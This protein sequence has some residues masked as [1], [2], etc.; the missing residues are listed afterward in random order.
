MKIARSAAFLPIAV[1]AATVTAG[2]QGAPPVEIKKCS[3]LRY[4]PATPAYRRSYWYDYGFAGPIVPR[5]SP[6][7]DGIAISFVNRSPK[8]ADRVVFGVDYRGDFQHV[9]DAGSFTTGAGIDHTFADVFSG[10]AFLGDRPNSCV[11]RVVRFVDGS[12]WHAA[13]V[14]RPQQR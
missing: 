4:R 10:Y 2:A 13:G 12:T 11:V 7:T 5:D 14:G 3:V 8:T 6:Y 1:L 9:V